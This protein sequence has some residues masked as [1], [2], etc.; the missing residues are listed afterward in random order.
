[1]TDTDLAST[2]IPKSDQLNADDLIAGPMTITITKVSK[3]KG[4]Q[5]I[6]INFEGDNGRPYK[7]GKSMRRVLVLVWGGNGNHYVGEA[8][9]L[10]RDPEVTF[11]SDKVGGI[12]ISHMSGID[13]PRELA[14]TVKRG[15]RKP[16][17]VKPL[18]KAAKRPAAAD[19]AEP[20]DFFPGEGVQL[21][22]V[23]FDP[24]EPKRVAPAPIDDLNNGEVQSVGKA[25][26]QLIEKAP[27]MRDEW[28]EANAADLE[29][30]KQ[31][32]AKLHDFIVAP[33][34]SESA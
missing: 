20:D 32:S 26:R 16:F 7:P 17:H 23:I 9:T 21:A 27:A 14:I 24:S 33:L 11:G 29:A 34:Q 8:L 28:L 25:L 6:I 2:I 1:M 12:R 15:Q 5:P 19:K 30:I 3:V 10:Y 22:G 18:V 13:G 4:E 31:R